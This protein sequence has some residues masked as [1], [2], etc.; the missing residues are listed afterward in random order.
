MRSWF[1]VFFFD[2]GHPFYRQLTPPKTRYP[3]TR[4]VYRVPV[5]PASHI[6]RR[7]LPTKVQEK[8]HHQNLTTCCDVMPVFSPQVVDW[9]VVW[10]LFGDRGWCNGWGGLLAWHVCGGCWGIMHSSV[11]MLQL[12]TRAIRNPTRLRPCLGRIGA[13]A[14]VG[15]GSGTHIILRT[16]MAII[17]PN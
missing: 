3:L 7:W 10:V 2:I 4:V 1:I 15:A 14:K 13:D 12:I 5:D 6:K 8:W 16:D 9:V 11:L 17:K